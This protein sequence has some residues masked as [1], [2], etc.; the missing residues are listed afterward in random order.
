MISKEDIEQLYKYNRWANS[1]IFK[2]V[3]NLNPEQFNQNLGGSF[4]SV[5]E[6]L[7][8]M[9]GADWVWLMRW[10]GESPPGLLSAADFPTLNSI[11][12]KWGDIETEQIEFVGKVTDLSLKAPLRYKN[13]KGE[14][15][16]YPLGR[17]MQHLVNHG[18]YHRGQVTNFLRQLGAQPVSTDFIVYLKL[19]GDID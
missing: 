14:P 13:L 4:P 19:E 3:A 2:T 9:M 15:F 12:T 7:I 8:H 10:K 6:T 5:R 18:S 11:K 17:T 1:A 16:E